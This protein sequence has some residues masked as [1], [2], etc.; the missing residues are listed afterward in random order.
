MPTFLFCYQVWVLTIQLTNF[1]KQNRSIKEFGFVWFFCCEQRRPLLARRTQV[2]RTPWLIIIMMKGNNHLSQHLTYTR[3]LRSVSHA[4]CVQCDCGLNHQPVHHEAT[5]T[6]G[7]IAG[8]DLCVRGSR[9]QAHGESVHRHDGS[10]RLSPS[11]R[12]VCERRR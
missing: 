6:L 12:N 8:A 4:Q 9:L 1:A 5:V 10:D 3:C 11:D 2:E 7:L